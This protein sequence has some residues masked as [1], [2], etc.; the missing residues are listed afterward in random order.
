MSAD[1]A[2]DAIRIVRIIDAPRE[3]V[4]RAWTEP[5]QIRSWWG[6]GDFTC[7]EAEVDL[8]PGG[9]YR[10]AMQPAAGDPFIVVGIYREIQS[11]ARLTYT[12]RWE[13]GPAADGSESLVTVEFREHGDGTEVVL[14]HTEFPA[15]HGPAPYR[16]GWEGGLDKFQALFANRGSN[17]EPSVT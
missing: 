11:P 16:M 14:T 5:E 3:Q 8:R 7:P 2:Q 10:L 15:A 12:W 1:R 6:P 13:T 17:A 9:S 4:F